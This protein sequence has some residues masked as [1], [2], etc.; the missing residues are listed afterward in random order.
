[1]NILMKQEQT[2]SHREQTCGCQ[3]GVGGRDGLGVWGQQMQ[4]IIYRIDRQQGPIIQHRELYS[5]SC[6]KPLE[7]NRK[8]NV[9]IYTHTYAY[10]CTTESLCCAIEINTTL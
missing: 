10:I 7:K 4:T 3:G 6:D 5:I 2:H 9:Y 8:K 1:M